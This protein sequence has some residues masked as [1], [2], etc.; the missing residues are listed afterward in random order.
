MCLIEG[1]DRFIAP[2]T[3]D[4]VTEMLTDSRPGYQPIHW[5]TP[6]VRLMIA[7]AFDINKILYI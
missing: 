4:I 3:T 7:E 6:P 2:H 1:V 5:W